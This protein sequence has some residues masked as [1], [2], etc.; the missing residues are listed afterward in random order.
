MNSAQDATFRAASTAIVTAMDTLALTT[1]PP[2]VA[3]LQTARNVD[4]GVAMM[5][6]ADVAAQT[7]YAALA[8]YVNRRITSGAYAGPAFP[9]P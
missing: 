3:T 6:T 2:L 5:A 1:L 9:I 4:P 7:L 8:V